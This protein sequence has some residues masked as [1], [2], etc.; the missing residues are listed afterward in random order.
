MSAVVGTICRIGKAAAR[1]MK[2]SAIS[3]LPEWSRPKMLA[4]FL[5]IDM[6]TLRQYATQGFVERDSSGAYNTKQVIEHR[7]HIDPEH[8]RRGKMSM[9]SRGIAVDGIEVEE[10]DPEDDAL[11]A[12][13]AII[14]GINT[15]KKREAHWKAVKAEMLVLTARGKLI[16]REDAEAAAEAMG[17]AIQMRMKNLVPKLRPHMGDLGREI[18]ENEVHACLSEVADALEKLAGEAEDVEAEHP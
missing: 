14:P 17:I 1:I 16:D 3:D 18:L 12:D 10:D 4:T 6:K 8:T 13:P 7:A 5:G 9:Q 15:S 2:N 11:N